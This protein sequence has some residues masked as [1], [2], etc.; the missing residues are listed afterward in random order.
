MQVLQGI[1]E[2]EAKVKAAEGA[3]VKAAE[4]VTEEAQPAGGVQQEDGQEAEGPNESE[5]DESAEKAAEEAAEK[6]KAE[7]ERK[8]LKSEKD[9]LARAQEKDEVHIC[10]APYMHAF[11]PAPA[12]TSL[13]A[14]LVHRPTC[15]HVNALGRLR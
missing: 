2:E 8:R 13:T 9:N 3:K 4:E 14:T 7:A 1:A 15:S 11:G 6:K 10:L 5:S 12:R